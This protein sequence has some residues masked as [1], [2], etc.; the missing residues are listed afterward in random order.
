[1][2]G[3]HALVLAPDKHLHVL[4]WIPEYQ[5]TKSIASKLNELAIG[6]WI[7][8]VIENGTLSYEKIEPDFQT[9]A[10]GSLLKVCLFVHL[11]RY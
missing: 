9:T 6:N 10:E 11:V 8:F 7:K 1:M 4:V 5:T 2:A 3:R